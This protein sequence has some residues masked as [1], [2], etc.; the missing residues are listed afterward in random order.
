MQSVCACQC[1]SVCQCASVCACQCVHATAQTCFESFGTQCPTLTR[2][3][4]GGVHARALL[5]PH[6]R[7]GAHRS[8]SPYTLP[9]THCAYGIPRCDT[10]LR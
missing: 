3:L 5:H 10:C 6:R 4:A 7:Q 9:S 1:V 8:L 2:S